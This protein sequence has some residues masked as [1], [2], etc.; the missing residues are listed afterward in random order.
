MRLVSDDYWA[1]ATIW[2]ESSGEPYEGKVAVGEV[3]RNRTATKF[4]SNGSVP[5][6]VLRPSQFSCWNATS[7]RR[8]LAAM[9]DGSDPVVMDCGKAWVESAES[10]LT[11]G[12][13]SYFNPTW[14]HP[15]WANGKP[16]VQIG[17][18]LFFKL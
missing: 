5:D 3:I 9:L 17:N 11:N 16:T 4:F 12:A 1:I 18:H 13:N 2:M 10:E 15:D 14:V 7:P 8:G 6:T